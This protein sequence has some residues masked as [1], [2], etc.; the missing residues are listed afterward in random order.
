MALSGRPFAR[1]VDAELT[2]CIAGGLHS[3]KASRPVCESR[4]DLESHSQRVVIWYVADT[5]VPQ[6]GLEPEYRPAYRL[7]QIRDRFW[8]VMTKVGEVDQTVVWDRSRV[9]DAGVQE[10]P[11][12]RRDGRQDVRLPLPGAEPAKKP[13]THGMQ[14]RLCSPS[15]RRA[16]SRVSASGLLFRSSRTTA[17][18]PQ[19]LKTRGSE[20]SPGAA[21]T[22]PA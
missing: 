8:E 10:H 20:G 9:S 13:P 21:H 1:S 18:C 3:H 12:M 15:R 17:L 2:R 6:A 5:H 4:Y 16:R 22:K 7:L 14:S 11:K 19:F